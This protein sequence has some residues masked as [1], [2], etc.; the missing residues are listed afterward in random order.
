LLCDQQINVKISTSL[1][2]GT[3]GRWG[4]G[5]VILI[6]LI[7][8]NENGG[9]TTFIATILASV[10][11]F[12]SAICKSSVQNIQMAYLRATQ[13]FDFF[14]LYLAL[15]LDI[16]TLL[17]AC[18]ALA[19]TLSICLDAM[20]GGMARIYLLGRN[21]DENEPWP[22]VLGVSVVFLLTVMFML[23]LENTKVFG[24]LMATGV[25]GIT[26]IT[27]ALAFI[28]GNSSEWHNEKILP[29]GWYGLLSSTALS[30]FAFPSE[31]PSNASKYKTFIGFGIFLA[32][33]LSVVVTAACLSTIT[34]F[35]ENKSFIAVPIL[36]ILE[37]Q[38]FHKVEPAVACLLVLT[39]SGAFL[40]L[41]PEMYF[42][43]VKLT[44]TEYKILSRQIGYENGD[45][46]SPILAIFT[47]GSLC[48]MLAF[49]C[50]LQNLITI[51]AASNLCAGICRAFYLLY[52]PY[53]PKY[54]EIKSNEAS[55]AYSRLNAPRPSSSGRSLWPFNKP[56]VITITSSKPR[57]KNAKRDIELEREWLLL[58][59]PHSPLPRV[60]ALN[61]DEA[62]SS[63]LNEPEEAGDREIL[64]ESDSSTDIDAIVDE[65]RQKVKVEELLTEQHPLPITDLLQVS[66]AGMKTEKIIRIPTV[67]SWR[68]VLFLLFLLIVAAEITIF[69]LSSQ[70]S[71]LVLTGALTAVVT[72]ALLMF[73][74]KYNVSP[75]SPSSV[76]CTLTVFL[77]L[78]LIYSTLKNSWPAILFW[79]IAGVTLYIRCHNWCC[80]CLEQQRSHLLIPTVAS[81][82]TT[83]HIPCPPRGSLIQSRILGH[84]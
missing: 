12:F 33:T 20:T 39:C 23:G 65:Y 21:S 7:V 66:T 57:Q 24:V 50:P 84:R 82:M 15:W 75:S 72:S 56:K 47:G 13:K 69:G 67:N 48:A 46:G 37:S 80:L 32:A 28:R 76:T 79:I 62:E 35:S 58:G 43:I 19:R 31:L 68:F 8:Y 44:T 52:S 51:L 22:D 2:S 3:G 55:L 78:I 36:S 38:D 1:P 11:A 6:Y 61:S 29:N 64:T 81:N 17:T 34:E 54:M 77:E 53:R 25:V 41:F 73:V 10:C 45:S 71:V 26:I 16:L 70:S 9:P 83:I 74:P 60:A 30:I 63:I 59:E 18:G 49:A 14:C 42:L 4:F 27:I 40:E 5:V